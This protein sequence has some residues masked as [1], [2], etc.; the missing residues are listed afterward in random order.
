[1]ETVNEFLSEAFFSSV[2]NAN[3]KC[4]ATTKGSNRLVVDLSNAEMKE[5]LKNNKSNPQNCAFL[6]GGSTVSGVSQ[7]LDIAITQDCKLTS[8]QTQKVQENL[9]SQIN[10]E[11]TNNKNGLSE[12]FKSALAVFGANTNDQTSIRNVLKS[13]VS[14]VLT[15]TA[16]NQAV[17]NVNIENRLDFKNVGGNSANVNNISQRASV[18][19]I[20]NAI[21]NTKNG[22]EIKRVLEQ[23]VDTVAKKVETNPLDFFNIGGALGN[24][25][26][27]PIGLIT[28]GICACSVVLIA[29]IVI[30]IIYQAKTK[31]K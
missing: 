26:G 12:V 28:S 13:K 6:K 21:A 31:K 27:S 11:I 15:T 25:T 3:N 2:V 10:Q 16:V 22:A 17:K 20:Q 18:K 19:A 1:M 5:C 23:A 9:T 14:S 8:D 4:M 29:S 30:Y 24:L 7:T